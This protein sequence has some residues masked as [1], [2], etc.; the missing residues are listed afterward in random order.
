I[1]NEDNPPLALDSIQVYQLNRYMVAYLKNADSY[2]LKAGHKLLPPVYDLA[3]FKN[4]IPPTAEVII[5]APFQVYATADEATANSTF[6][7]SKLWIWA[8]LIV[9]I[10][11]LAFMSVRMIR[12]ANSNSR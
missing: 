12:E 6:F 2:K 5:P 11:A 3:S 7:N 4:K 8:A 1:R 9:I 10:G